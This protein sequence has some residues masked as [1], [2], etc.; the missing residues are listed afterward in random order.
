MCRIEFSIEAIEQSFVVPT[1]LESDEEQGQAS[2]KY[3]WYY[4]GR[5]NGYWLYD[6]RTMKEIEE[7]YQDP[8]RKNIEVSVAGFLYIIDFERLVQF[9]KADPNRIRKIKREEHESPNKQLNVK[10]IAGLRLQSASQDGDS[11]LDST[12]HEEAAAA[13]AG[14]S[15]VDSAM[16]QLTQHIADS[17]Q[18]VEEAEEAIPN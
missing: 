1:N 6:G 16:D 8:E 2:A 17:L 14:T 15:E 11:S 10:G 12:T 3:R 18:I 7:A 13:A 9:R 5:N 4:Q